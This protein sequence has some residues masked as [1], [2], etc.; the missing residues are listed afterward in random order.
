MGDLNKDWVRGTEGLGLIEHL[1]KENAEL[2]ARVDMGFDERKANA[3]LIAAAPDL[4]AFINNLLKNHEIGEK[5][6]AE[7]TALLAKARGDQ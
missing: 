5:L 6:D 3:R 7:M 4:Y 2:R 1:Q